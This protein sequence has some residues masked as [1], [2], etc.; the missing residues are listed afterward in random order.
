MILVIAR[1]PLADRSWSHHFR[2]V[3]L[4]LVWLGGSEVTHVQLHGSLQ[5]ALGLVRPAF[6]QHASSNEL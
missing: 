2:G 3:G 6:E 4:K 1:V 5:V